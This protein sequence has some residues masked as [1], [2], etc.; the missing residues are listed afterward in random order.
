MKAVITAGILFVLASLATAQSHPAGRKVVRKPAN[1]DLQ[2]LKDALAAQQQQ[3][4]TLQQQ[5][6]QTSQ[7]LQQ[8]SQQFQQTQQ[9]L[10][11]AQQTATDAQQRTASLESSLASKES[12]EKLGS[13][14]A[15]VE[16][17]LTN[18][19]LATQGEQKRVSA[20]ETSLGRFRWTGDVRVRSDDFFQRYS[21]CTTCNDRNR[22]RVRI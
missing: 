9:Q 6:Q 12:V 10:Q 21:G 18:N 2:E 4:Q 20:L 17:S 3:I 7:Q 19:A 13:Q 15:D 8:T 11:Q 16:T 1:A 22:A 14:F 5:L